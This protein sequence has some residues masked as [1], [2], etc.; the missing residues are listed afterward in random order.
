M[1]LSM[2]S[3]RRRL[4]ITMLSLIFTVGIALSNVVPAAALASWPIVRLGNSG[5]NVS[6]V[7]YLLRHR[8]Y[9]L[10]AD[11]QFG[12]ITENQVKAFQQANGL[13]ADGVVGQNTWTKLVVTLDRGA[14]N[15][16]VKGLQVQ[17]NK[18]GYNLV[19][20]GIYGSG[21]ETAVLNFKQK[22]GLGSG[23]TVGSTTWQELTGSTSTTW[24]SAVAS[25]YGPGLYG[26]RT[27]CGQTL[28]TTTIGVAHLTMPCGTRLMFQGRS[29]QIVY[30]NVIDRGPYVSGR[31]FDLTEA[32]VKQM[33]YAS[34]TD[35]GVRTVNWNYAP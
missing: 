25:S 28:T 16:A 30:A 11:G 20:D 19:V 24:Q 35:F 32:T 9:S 6:T 27:A 2:R 5:P 12:T 13:V 10:T 34:T 1:L 22:R 4:L 26:N 23:S 14:Q 21:T 29:G 33:G 7:Q 3:P 8:G 17:L 15:E 31:T 18:H